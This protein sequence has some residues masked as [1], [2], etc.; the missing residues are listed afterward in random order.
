M[1]WPRQIRIFSGK[2][3]VLEDTK[4]DKT[5]QRVRGFDL[6]DQGFDHQDAWG[7]G[8]TSPGFDLL[9]QE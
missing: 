8:W 2:I 7:R 1:S 3:T 9:D 4:P 5:D 6:N